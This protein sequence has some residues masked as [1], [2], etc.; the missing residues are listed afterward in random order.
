MS[1]ISLFRPD[2]L[3]K[4]SSVKQDITTP[5]C[6]DVHAILPK[7][8]PGTESCRRSLLLLLPN[9]IT[10]EFSVCLDPGHV[11]GEIRLVWNLHIPVSWLPI[12]RWPGTVSAIPAW[13]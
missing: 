8:W 10:G 12:D 3:P 2:P 7:G 4:H 11:P 13:P 5:A 9:I 6:I 1:D